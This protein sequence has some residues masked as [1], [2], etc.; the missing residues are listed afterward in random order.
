M[1]GFVNAP[2]AEYNESLG[3]TSVR[4]RIYRG[5][6]RDESVV[7]FVRNDFIQRTTSVFEVLGRYESNFEAKEFDKMKK[8][9]QEF[10]DILNNDKSFQNKILKACRAD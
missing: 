4:E 3:I 2:Y 10:F 6:C 5:F 9:I 1:A 7:Q 8:Y